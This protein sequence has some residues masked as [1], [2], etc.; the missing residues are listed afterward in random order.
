MFRHSFYIEYIDLPKEDKI[1]FFKN[2][3]KLDVALSQDLWIGRIIEYGIHV[4]NKNIFGI[5]DLIEAEIMNMINDIN[6]D[7]ASYVNDSYKEMLALL[8]YNIKGIQNGRK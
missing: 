6:N 5:F 7:N 3:V 1:V 4:Y 8:K 2:K